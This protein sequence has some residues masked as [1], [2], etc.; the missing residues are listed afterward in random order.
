MLNVTYGHVRTLTEFETLF[1]KA[2]Y[3][4]S[5]IYSLKQDALSIIEVSVVL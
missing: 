3:S 1:K 5:Q 4:I 2:G